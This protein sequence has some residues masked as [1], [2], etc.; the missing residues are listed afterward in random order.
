[1]KPTVPLVDLDADTLRHL[2]HLGTGA[3]NL[4]RV[5]GN[6]PVL[7]RAWLDFA[8]TLRGEAATD[9]RFRE[10]MI[11]RCALLAGSEYQWNDHEAMALEAGV[12]PSQIEALDTWDSSTNFNEE[13]RLLLR[14]TDEVVAG[15]VSDEILEEM[16]GRYGPGD[17]VELTMTAAFYVMVPRVLD[18]L[19]VPPND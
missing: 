14:F 3:R 11:L 18:A 17:V 4:Y 9:R 1:M 15:H 6:N 2:E 13:E 19:R 10:L 7:L 8:W 12:E 5:I 16:R